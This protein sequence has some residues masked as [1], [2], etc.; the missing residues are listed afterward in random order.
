MTA[1]HGC[2]QEARSKMPGSVDKLLRRDVRTTAHV[3]SML[4][5]YLLFAALATALPLTILLSVELWMTTAYTGV[6]DLKTFTEQYYSSVFRYRLLGRDLLLHLY[7]FL[8]SHIADKPYPLPRDPSGSFLLYCAYA[9]SNGAYL[10]VSNLLLLSLLWVKKKGLMDREL[11]LYFYY[12]LLLAMSMAVVTPY[13]QLAY[14]LLLVGVLGA[15]AKSQSIGILL[16][17]I[18]AIAG[19]LNR[20]TEFLLASFLLTMALFSSKTLAKKYWIYL[21]V[22]LVLSLGAYIG[23]RLMIPGRMELI[24]SLTFG[25]K[26]ALESAVVLVLLLSAGVA[27]AIRLY[28]NVS[29]AFVFLLFSFPYFLTVFIGGVFRELRLMVP[30]L[31]CLLCI[32]LFLNRAVEVPVERGSGV[33]LE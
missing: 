5:Q 18:S 33:T 14:L 28:N 2:S 8:N 19:T 29:P 6:M 23:V 16:V 12:M 26:W 15:R 4:P 24:Q 21:G 17:A 30:V 10:F 3:S 31:L 1:A 32:Y 25:G 13:D 7:Y 27:L 22:D 20:E 11:L 9:I